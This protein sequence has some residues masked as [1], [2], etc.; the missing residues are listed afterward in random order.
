MVCEL[1]D[2]HGVAD[3]VVS[4]KQTVRESKK[5]ADN[6]LIYNQHNFDK[7]V[8]FDQICEYI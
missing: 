5:M 2:V 3:A 8:L 7:G 1:G 6:A 4:L